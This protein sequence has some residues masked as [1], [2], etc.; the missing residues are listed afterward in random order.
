[1]KNFK[2]FSYIEIGKYL[3]LI[4]GFPFSSGLFSN[5]EG[6][7]LIR[8]RDIQTS[9]I[10]TYYKGPYL[11]T[12]VI[13]RGDI[14]VGMDG[15][16][17]V[18]K[19]WNYKGLL[20]QRILKIEVS[21]HNVISLRFIYYWL[22]PY[23]QKINDITAATTVKHLSI[24]DI[25]KASGL[26]PNIKKQE[27]IASILESIDQTIE[28]TEAL[29]HKYQQIKAGLMQD[30]FT[31]GV[32]ADGK[33]R[34]PREHAPE[35]YK[36]SPVGWIPKEW[37][38]QSLKQRVGAENIIN[39]PF[40]SDLLT[41][42]LYDEGVPVLYVQDIKPGYFKRIST[43]HVTKHKAIALSFCNVRE[44]DVLVAKVG[45]P[46]CDSCIYLY[47]EKAIVTQDVIRI[48]PSA[49]INPEY[50]SSL[51]NSPFGRS[52]IKKISI[53]GTR[54]RVSLTEFKNIKIPI[55]NPEEQ[56]TIGRMLS[57]SQKLIDKEKSKKSKLKKQK[58]G[59]MHDLLTG[60]VQVK[61]YQEEP[62]HV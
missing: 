58:S 45:S 31:R 5:E 20:N 56:Q 33:L 49:N 48:R 34:P 41:S 43:K 35:L 23:I 7:P 30:L 26:I 9:K 54:E 24:K 52:T 50:I 17:H 11:G 18:V 40:G 37:E 62:A 51:L 57:M 1:M 55:P 38:V 12:Y 47:N 14:L 16:F 46:P 27:K 32:T 29:I 8:I 60:K 6:F 13:N 4:S 61:V 2:S 59:L 36:E 19:W 39:G 25:E 42:E 53:E 28:K 15:D 22:I 3:K 21:N 44:N 10:E